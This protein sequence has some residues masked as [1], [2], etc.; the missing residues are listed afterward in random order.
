MKEVFS[1]DRQTFRRRIAEDLL[2]LNWTHEAMV[3]LAKAK[4]CH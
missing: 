2:R 3:E 4:A 1:Q